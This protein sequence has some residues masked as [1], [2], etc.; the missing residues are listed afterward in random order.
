[1]AEATTTPSKPKAAK[2]P[3]AGF[4][5]APE[6]PK[7]ELPKFEMPNFDMPKMEIPAAFRDI[8]EKSI[9]QC[10]DSYEKMKAAAEDATDVLEDTYSLASKGC[11]DYGLKLIELARANTNAAFDFAS[12]LYGVKSFA[13]FVELS[14]A[15]TRKQFD[16]LTAQSKELAALA[17]KVATE[18]SDPIKESMTKVFKK[19]A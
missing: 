11:A 18:T 14:T 4:I 3:I 15:H 12:E 10:K 7:F 19:A 5:P 9:S 8:A 16:T 1:M 2:P 6:M 17:Q 13:E